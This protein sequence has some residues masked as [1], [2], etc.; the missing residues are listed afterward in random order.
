MKKLIYIPN[1]L[2][3][4]EL[5]ILLSLSQ[6]ALDNNEDLTILTC[7]GFGKYSCPKNLYSSSIVCALCKSQTNKGL[8]NLK[9]NFKVEFTPKI[10][11]RNFY[12]NFERVK[13]INFMYK[14]SDLGLGV[15]ASYTN[16]LRDRDLNGYFSNNLVNNL[17]NTSIHLYNFFEKYLNLKRFDEIIVF[18]GRMSNVRPIF[19]AAKFL[20]N[21]VKFKLIEF[22]GY[23]NRIYNFNHHLPGEINSLY[24]LVKPYL[25]KKLNKNELKTVKKHFSDRLNGKLS[26][27]PK[28]Y[29]NKQQKNLLPEKW[30]PELKNIVYFTSSTDE[31]ESFG[32]ENLIKLF[33]DQTEAISYIAKYLS[34][35]R[36]INFWIRLHPNMKNINWKY[37]KKQRN[38]HNKYFNVRVISPESKVSSYAILKNCDLVI[39]TSDTST[40]LEAAYW[41]KPSIVI[42]KSLW[43]KIDISVRPKNLQSLKKLLVNK[44]PKIFSKMIA[45]NY[46]YF[47]TFGGFK[48]KYFSGNIA[49]KFYFKKKNIKFNFFENIVYKIYKLYEKLVLN[50]LINFCMRKFK[51]NGT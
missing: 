41:G 43:E 18:N 2:N 39:G 44:K 37:V 34:K 8:K 25:K 32:K 29:V 47:W 22:K 51:N 35:F 21:K 15:F 13:L 4:P 12:K 33:K 30:V 36:N 24:K 3:S 10:K 46:I 40:I 27:D 31:Y 6:T 7:S 1:G 20:K 14:K 38:L 23:K 45:Q 50:F 16:Q 9:G 26:L 5:E 48:N 17:L 11:V 42:G 28:S 19:S 49:S